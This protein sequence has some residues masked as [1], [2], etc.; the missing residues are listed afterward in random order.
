MSKVKVEYVLDNGWTVSGIVDRDE[1]GR[2][3][4]NPDDLS[5]VLTGFGPT[6]QV[7]VVLPAGVPVKG[8][9]SA[10]E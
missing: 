3:F 2:V 9:D 10:A 6:Q 8:S 7:V 5:E 1:A 4:R